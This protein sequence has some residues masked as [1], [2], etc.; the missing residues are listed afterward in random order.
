MVIGKETS[1][2][3]TLTLG[4]LPLLLA[5]EPKDAAEGEL[6]T[7]KGRGF[8]PAGSEDSVRVGGAAA[9]VVSAAEAALGVIVPRVG[10]AGGETAVEVRVAGSDN[11]GKHA[12]NLK[13]PADPVG[14]RF[15]LEPIVTTAGQDRVAVA[16]PL[17]PVFVLSASAGKTA[18]QRE[19]GRASCR[20]R[21]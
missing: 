10:S 7:L 3:Q 16:S 17:G 11:V 4:R 2:P 13:A 8:K 1:N 20:E 15:T 18:A 9:V 12:F 14:L 5:I 21:V 6:I 19:I